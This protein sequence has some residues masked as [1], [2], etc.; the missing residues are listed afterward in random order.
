MAMAEDRGLPTPACMVW[1]MT[2]S[3][4]NPGNDISQARQA[5]YDAGAHRVIDTLAELPAALVAMEQGA[6]SGSNP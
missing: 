3:P 6:F 2:C 5:L 1:G 4:R